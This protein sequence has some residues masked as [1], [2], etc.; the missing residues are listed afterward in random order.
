MK[1]HF[2]RAL[3]HGLLVLLSLTC[4]TAHAQD[5]AGEEETEEPKEKDT[6]TLKERLFWGGGIN[7]GFGT[8]TN[9]GVE[10]IIGYKVDRAN[11]WSVGV[12]GTYNYFRQNTAAYNYETSIYGYKAFTRYKI[13]PQF[14]VHS[15]FNQ[16]SYQL[17]NGGAGPRDRLWIPYLLVGGGYAANIGGRTYLTFQALWDVIQDPNSPYR[18]GT[19]FITG[20]F[21]VGF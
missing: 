21:A 2:E 9:I 10:P 4:A 13:L 5:Y 12:G 17:Y 7:I 3:R 19:P 1:T 8:V 18:A 15:E 16:F 6:R 11:R 14:F 20:G